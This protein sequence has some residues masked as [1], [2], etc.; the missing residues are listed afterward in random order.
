VPTEN[1]IDAEALAAHARD[2]QARLLRAAS[3]GLRGDVIHWAGEYQRALEAL[4][5]TF[6][7]LGID[8][9]THTCK[10]KE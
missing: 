3:K 2:C 7:T 1:V 5:A 9:A 6:S 8:C 4:G 10:D